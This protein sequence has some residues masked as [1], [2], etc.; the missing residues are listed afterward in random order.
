MAFDNCMRARAVTNTPAH[1]SPSLASSG[2]VARMGWIRSG[3]FEVD[4]ALS[5][6]LIAEVKVYRHGEAVLSPDK[7]SDFSLILLSGWMTASVSLTHG[8]RQISEIYLKGD[9]F[10]PASEDGKSQEFL[11]AATDLSVLRFR[12]PALPEAA[13]R[14]PDLVGW[15]ED[16]RHRLRVLSLEHLAALGN[17][18][19]VQRVSWLLLRLARRIANGS[20]GISADFALPLTQADLA[21]YLGMTAVHLNRTIRKLRETNVAHVRNGHIVIPDLSRLG[22]SVVRDFGTTGGMS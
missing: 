10:E 16:Q 5:N 9:L 18:S 22:M 20:T 14:W 6:G 11:C 17:C 21:D 1:Q 15:Q 8:K 7:R 2:A 3:I 12:L 19:A 13:A 4:N